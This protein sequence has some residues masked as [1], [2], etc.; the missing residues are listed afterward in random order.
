MAEDVAKLRDYLKR[1]TVDLR[2]ARRRLQEVEDRA[3]EPIAIIGMACR[4]PGGVGSPDELW[5][6]LVEERDAIGPFP[7]DRGWDLERLF[8][9]GPGGTTTVREGGFLDDAAGFDAEFFG[10]SPREALAMEP[11]QRLLLESAW[12][13]LEHAGIDPAGLEE[14][15]AGVFVGRNYHEYGAP[16]E[17]APG[18]VEGH[19]VTGSVAS[20][21]SGRIAYTLGLSGPA[22]TVDTAC[23]TS[24]VT[25]HLAAQSL[26]SGESDLAL[27]GGATVM[28]TPGT[29]VEFGKQGALAADGRCKAFAAGSDGMGMAEGVGVLALE[30]LSDARRRGHRVLAVVRGS[31]VNQDGASNGLTAPSGPAQQQ[32]IWA[33]L[34]N[35]G[36]APG[37]VDAVEAHGTG[38][39]LGDPIEGRA[40]L[41]T[42]GQGRTA[43]RPLW[44]GSVKSNIGHTQAAAGVAGIIKTVLAMR[45]GRLPRTLHVDEPTPHVD[46][47]SG[48][49]RLLTE[50]RAWPE[51]D[52]PRRAAVSSFGI[53]GTN[54][55]VILEQAPEAPEAAEQQPQARP[56]APLWPL[57]A[58]TPRALAA[59]GARL[60]AYVER[61]PDTEP[62]DV[63][64]TLATSRAGHR[65]RAVVLDGDPAALAALAEGAA[66]PCL[67]TGPATGPV[68]GALAFLFSGQ[69]SQHPGMGRDLYAAFPA[70]AEA[71]DETTAALDPHLD[72]PLREVMFAGEGSA[73]A[74]LLGRTRYA[75]PALF[76]YEVALFRLLGHWGITP[77]HLAGHS[78]GD[79]AA[80]HCAGVLGLA[81]AGLLV[82][83]RARLMQEM[84]AT[85]VMI[86]LHAAA[87][88]VAPHLTEGVTIAALN[89][90][91]ATVISGD[92]A[93]ARAVA[94]RFRS[95][96]LHVSHAFHSPHMDGMLEPFRE[97][98]RTLTFHPPRIP[99]ATDADRLRDPEHWVR[100]VREPVRFADHLARLA[101]NGAGAFLE[102][103]PDAALTTLAGQTFADGTDHLAVPLQRRTRDQ[104]H[105]LLTALATLHTHH[106]ASPAWPALLP[107]ARLADDLPTYPFQHKDYWLPPFAPG[108]SLAGRDAHP[109]I[110]TVTRPA[111]GDRL[112]LG[113][114]L[115]L[116]THP[117]LAGHAVAGSVLL[118]GTA[119]VELA[120]SAAARLD[121]RDLGVEELTLHAPLVLPDAGTVEIQV[122]VAEADAAGRREIRIHARPEP[123]G[124]PPGPWTEHASGRLAALPA[125]AADRQDPAAWPPAGAE[126]VAVDG[127]YP[128]LAALGLSYGPVFTGVRAAWRRGDEV[129]AEVV[130]PEEATADA[131]RFGIHPALLDAA[132]H[133]IGLGLGAGREPDRAQL[134]F[135]FGGVRLE[136]VAATAVRVRLAPA[137]P[138]AVALTVADALGQP[139]AAVDAL[140]TRPFAA[141][142]LARP[143]TDSLYRLDWAP[144]ATDTEAAGPAGAAGSTG[145]GEIAEIGEIADTAALPEIPEAVVLPF[146]EAADATAALHRALD[147]ARTWLAD[148]RAAAA[149]ARLVVLTRR[150]V[151]AA[152]GDVPDLATAPVWGLLRSAQSEAPGRFVL[153]DLDDD[154]AAEDPARTVRRVLACGEPQVAVRAGRL[155]A[156]RLVR[157]RAPAPAE[158]PPGPRWDPDG[159]VLITGG[160]GTLAGLLA[161]HLV[162]EHGVRHLLLAGRSGPAAAGATALRDELT[163]LGATVTVAACDLADRDAT[164]RLLDGIPAAHPLTAVVHLAGVVE[165]GLLAGLTS[166]QLDRVLAPKVT[167]ALHLHELT[168]A[169]GLPLD[170]FVLFSSAASVL[171]GAGQGAYAGANA[172]LDALA[173]H[174]RAQG[175]PAVALGWGLWERMSG[176]TAGLGA[177][178]RARMAR[179]GVAPLPDAEALALFDAA[180][181][182]AGSAE[183]GEP[184][185]LPVRL[186][187]AALAGADAP[188][189]VLR[190]LVRTPGRRAVSAAA[191]GAGAP[192]L[193]ERLAALPGAERATAALDLVRTQT[194][195]VLGHESPGSV[196]E[197]QAFR[198]LGFDSLMA[199]DLR[200]GLARETGLRLPATL[201][202][203][204]PS[205]AALAGFLL[206]EFGLGTETRADAGAGVPRAAAADDPIAIVGMACR[207]PGGVGSPEELWELVAAGRDAISDFPADRGWDPEELYDPDPD[208]AGRSSVWSGGFLHG[209]ADFDPGFFGLSPREA[210][211]MDPQQRLLLE[212]SWEAFERAGIDPESARGSR[213][214]VFTGLM[215]HD[216]AAR[217]SR[218]PAELE[219]YLGNGSAGSVATGRVAYTFGLEG[220]AV[221]VDTACSSSLVALHLAAQSLRTGECDLALAGGVTVMSAL[222]AFIEFSRQRALAPD[223]RCKSFA[224]AADGTGWAEGVGVLV[225]ERLSAARR[226]GH[227]VL[228]VVRGSAVNQDG[229]SNG[230]TAPN[231]PSQQRVIRAALAHAGLGAA[232]VDAVE[233][234]GTGTT[235][236]D[237]IEAEALLA[238]YGRGRAAERPVWLGSVKSNIGHTQAAAGVAGIIKMVQ[239][240][241]HGELPRTLHVDEPTPHVDW[242]SGAVRLLT[243]ARSWPEV[244]RPRRAA[245]SSFGVSGTNA[246]V[247]LEQAEERGVEERAEAP[248]VTSWPLSGHTATALRAQ[249]GRLH[250]HLADHP[251]VSLSGVADALSA[252]AR[253]DERAVVV[254]AERA[255]LA[256]G[257]EALAAGAPHD[258]VVQGTVV[259][260]K[261]VFVYPGQGSQWVRMGARLLE[262]SA[263]FADA[264]A[265]C[266][267]ALAPYTDF[268]LLKVLTGDDPAVLEPV[269]VVQPALWAVMV[270]LTR[271]WEHHG[272]RPDAVIGHSQGEIAAAHAAGALSLDDAAR[273][274]AL[275]SRA[276]TA[277]AG[278]GGMLSVALDET[279]AEGLLKNCGVSGDVSVAAFNGPAAVVVAGPV[280]ALDAVQEHCAAHDIRHRRV[281]VTYASHTALVQPLEADLGK[282]LSGIQPRAA[283]I[284]FYSTVTAG[285]VDTTTL[286]AGYWFTNLRSPVRFHQTV[287]AL[288]ADGY[289]H[290]LEPSP[291]PGL[292]TAIEE[293]VDAADA[294]AVTHATLH[295]D[296][297]SPHRLA[298]AR[299]H[300]HAHGLA[301]R[302]S[303][304]PPAHL[305]DLPT[306][307]FQHQH[308]WLDATPAAPAA[309]ASHPLVG[310]PVELAGGDGLLFT[311]SLS[312]RTHP[313]LADHAVAGTVLLPGTALLELALHTGHHAGCAH[314]DELAL[315]APL[316]LLDDG[317]VDLQ[318][319]VGGADEGGRRTVAVYA[320]PRG[321]AAGEPWSRHATAT[322]QPHSPQAPPPPAA[323]WPPADATP[324][325]LTSLYAHLDA[326]GL[327]YGPAFRGLRAAWR[328]GGDILAEVTLPDLADPAAPFAVHPA[329]LDAA[330]HAIGLDGRPGDRPDGAPRLPFT[331]QGVHL[332]APAAPGPATLRARLTPAGPDAVALAAT[333]ADGAPAVFVD[334]LA[335]RP[336][337]VAELRTRATSLY[338][339][340]WSAP[341][342][343]PGARTPAGSDDDHPLLV[344]GDEED[345]A[346]VPTAARA[347]L[348]RTLGAL[349]TW[350]ADEQ[351]ADRRLTVVTRNAVALGDESPNL[352][353]APVWGLVRS[354]QEEHPDRLVLVDTDDREESRHAL[355][356]AVAS[357]EPQLALRGGAL[358]VPRLVRVPLRP[359]PAAPPAPGYADGT[360]LVTGGTGT[361]GA[362]VARHLV[363][364]HGAT[365]LLLTSRRGA[366]APGADALVAELT[367][368]GADVTVAACDVA[369]REALA[370]L[371]A[372]IPAGRP[373]T[374]VVHAAGT[375]ADGVL[376]SLTPEA[377]DRVLAPKAAAAWALHELTRALPRPP[378]AFVLFSS[379]AGT[380][381]SAGQSNYAAANAF[382]D[383]LAHHRRAAGLPA[384]S[385]AWG[386]WESASGITG[387]LDAADRARIGRTGVAPLA[388][389]EALALFDAALAFPEGRRSPALAPVRL[390]PARLRALAAAGEL[391]A[392]LRRLVQAPAAPGAAPAAAEPADDL[393]ARLSALPEAEQEAALLE[394]VRAQVA[395]VL[396]HADRAQIDAERGFKDLGF[397]S[398]MAMELRNRLQRATGTRLRATLVFDFPAPAAV[399]AH[400]RE[401]LDLGTA[402]PAQALL[403]ELDRLEESLTVLAG[404]AAALGADRGR[405]TV[406]LRGLLAR[407]H[408]EPQDPGTTEPESRGDLDAATDD[409]LFD[410]VENLGNS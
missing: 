343:R 176:M 54:A 288:L 136:A 138:D 282:R 56:G 123:G 125:P 174:R 271:W 260:G 302:A 184:V 95:R 402:G 357:G 106:A 362:L 276:L 342:S 89:S 183:S 304:P 339:V 382:L 404:S 41:A 50:A 114:R 181:A 143:A 185:L 113:G 171:G 292:L 3:A 115:S 216:Y 191:P 321:D 25:L 401:R 406:R 22:V 397:D 120:L 234:H 168:L 23:S 187:T 244:D 163:A 298:L 137:G 275:R 36:L 363:A 19:L 396:G 335:L 221:T 334:R 59:Q 289:G 179:S 87:D 340:E 30:R 186:D 384:T 159:T 408:D 58:K 264:L 44:L 241:R 352:C 146:G 110:E 390:V 364:E 399:A 258:G 160:T 255:E 154:A 284:P 259:P 219:P 285:P 107:G 332:H 265:E 109:F 377:V 29:F 20:V 40:L 367:E 13:A 10:I 383:S 111:D 96:E 37:D 290:F 380:G 12:A 162:T 236:G 287:Q 148:E 91:T 375:V 346:D 301:T 17:Y 175:L 345:A 394:L 149:D 134:P 51:A 205:P 270:A 281:P 84:P 393:V 119:Y 250:T 254:G 45:H 348:L 26:R 208:R 142:R 278:T 246:H 57:S 15:K 391:P 283:D 121:E 272:V 9:P 296:D 194:A 135:S 210:L 105:T 4:F 132:L 70:F 233:A 188:A 169:R 97:V 230:L 344:V 328:H 274:V 177:A 39:E 33:A 60:A 403:G 27:A 103:G 49:V 387:A 331:W 157:H 55:H 151:A 1:V 192:E 129:F 131:A 193:R 69:G 337:P 224:A 178:D 6:L 247:I 369:D 320:R 326:T 223:G 83:T 112:V 85:G 325:S 395:D 371:L 46:W 117:W 317:A 67:V 349:Q 229:A 309:P 316:V 144:V 24:L 139:V 127:L 388:T 373:L 78:V 239:A 199:V 147:V 374:A 167:G 303:T 94:E 293:T 74:G 80:A 122:L 166:G 164:A 261:T 128:G 92:A 245:V 366:E 407:W 333:Y 118:P 38:T 206:T 124:V 228:A 116:R 372:G 90:P 198:D 150:A 158:P 269:E 101:E 295:R 47:E 248:G 308:L 386:L 170:A 232:D 86:S 7:A 71:L 31:A 379:F 307:P 68:A 336:L 196:P 42:Y 77:G 385:L 330:L 52:R 294:E 353:H 190:G 11:Q 378:A 200:N 63:A 100:H 277:L 323:V 398:L 262:E 256:A 141:D 251:D 213:T 231:G 361:L 313:W 140:V 222:Q 227:R 209:A 350:L 299:A 354:A 243:E 61:H 16:L 240:M 409:D 14:A 225:L 93:E 165:D 104:R 32:V 257:L 359:D 242:E 155:T 355:T 220:P 392:L 318:V 197:A 280:A 218:P 99:M 182:S 215:Y 202:F 130:L 226:N 381:G 358:S 21:A 126:P 266:G 315:E 72:R 365:H 102:V 207:Y 376:D 214:G 62:A 410:L 75:Q 81:D 249:A 312:L 153:V 319:T 297:D 82:T 108:T 201:V 173:R 300:T 48:A 268:D 43:D 267:E 405:I 65:H 98:V 88:E 5:R 273:V 2:K 211:A 64:H 238:T 172:F 347:V 400:L 204:Y 212:T 79:V 28:Y 235:L 237:P 152:P 279:G 368:L 291:H 356:A 8:G 195:T 180:C 76:A 217:V 311:G 35:A 34:D 370:A 253:F 53:S 322:V 73:E 263:V 389:A 133:G 203:D 156:P 252:R 286:T 329:L 341:P 324:L 305:P 18:A 351:N 338:E 360:V 314:L 145:I 189:P 327:T 161:A 306:Y 66:H 310:P